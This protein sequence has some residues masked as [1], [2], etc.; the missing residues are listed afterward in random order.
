MDPPEDVERPPARRVSYQ[1]DSAGRASIDAASSG[2][3]GAGG[4]RKQIRRG[5]SEGEVLRPTSGRQNPLSAAAEFSWRERDS[6]NLAHTGTVNADSPYGKILSDLHALHKE[7][8]ADRRK[9]ARLGSLHERRLST[10]GYIEGQGSSSRSQQ[11]SYRP[12]SDSKA[13]ASGTSIS[14]VIDL[15]SPERALPTR[16]SPRT[17]TTGDRRSRE[18]VLPRWQA[19]TEVLKCPICGTGFNFWYRKHHCR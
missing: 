1:S 18:I 15:T 19:D 7:H 5:H 10:S 14:D 2:S 4:T 16:S 6:W 11:R 9:R 8:D 17:S 12:A 13:V 3:Y